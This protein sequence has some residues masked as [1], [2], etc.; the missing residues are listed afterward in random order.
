M[1][2]NSLIPNPALG[3]RNEVET[4]F[5]MPLPFEICGYCKLLA[6]TEYSV[7]PYDQFTSRNERNKIRDMFCKECPMQGNVDCD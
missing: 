5:D 6:E 1:S 3:L 4:F 2:N 7:L